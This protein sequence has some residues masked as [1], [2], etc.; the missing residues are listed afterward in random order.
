MGFGYGFEFLYIVPEHNEDILV[1][2]KFLNTPYNT[3]YIPYH[4][5]NS[6]DNN[7][8]S[9]YKDVLYMTFL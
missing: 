1:Y 5:I 6:L 2:Y 8:F 7:H 3:Y 9:C 4:H